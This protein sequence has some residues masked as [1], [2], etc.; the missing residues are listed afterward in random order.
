MT[1]VCVFRLIEDG[2]VAITAVVH[3][4]D[5]FAVGQKERCD[6]LC[7][8]LNRTIPVKN[9]G[10]LKW[11]GGCRYSRDRKRGTLT[12]SQQ[13]FAQELVKKFRVTSVQSV[14]LKVGVKLEEFDEN[15]ET[16]SWPFRELVGGLMWL[17]LSTRP[18]ISN[19]G[20][21]PHRKLSTGNR[22]LVFSHTSMV[23]VV[24]ALRTSEGLR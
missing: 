22:R 20:T 4:D 2:R 7:V 23:L 16:E 18:D 15:E 10:D 24:L 13:S 6:R 12:I 3:V 21:V 17:A 5:I 14:P 1:D 8:D 11:Y 9:L 19:A